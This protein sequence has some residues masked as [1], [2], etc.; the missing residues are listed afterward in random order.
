MAPGSDASWCAMWCACDKMGMLGTRCDV[1]AMWQDGHAASSPLAF[2]R[3]LALRCSPE[4]GVMTALAPERQLSKLPFPSGTPTQAVA[5][6]AWARA[7][8]SPSH[9]HVGALVRSVGTGRAMSDWSAF[10]RR[11]GLLFKAVPQ[12]YGSPARHKAVSHRPSSAPCPPAWRGGASS[13]SHTPRSR[14]PSP[15]PLELPERGPPRGLPRSEED[16][17]KAL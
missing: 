7:A 15:S 6:V 4:Q 3:S 16:T 8:R 2:Q 10:V 9:E 11:N 17:T 5:I 1:G 12:N 13:D 14:S